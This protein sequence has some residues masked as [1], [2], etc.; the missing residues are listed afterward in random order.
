MCGEDFALDG[1]LPI[2]FVRTYLSSR[3]GTPAAIGWGWSHNL[4]ESIEII[5]KG[6]RDWKTVH[7]QFRS[8][9]TPRPER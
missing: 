6:H 3:A 7:A 4:Q 1:P 9:V 5:V 2:Q 8:R